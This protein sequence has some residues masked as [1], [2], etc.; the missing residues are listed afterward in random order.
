MRHDKLPDT[1]FSLLEQIIS[2]DVVVI[3]E[4]KKDVA[5]LEKF[6]VKR[7]VSLEGYAL[8]E[9]VERV[10]AH[11]KRCVVLTDLD[12]KGRELYGTLARDLRRHGVVVDD[13]LRTFLFKETAI[14]QIEGLGKYI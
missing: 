7:I 3:V 10:C 14:R 12:K 1:F 11:D 8:F 2:E 6:G 4:G 9:V 5:A 13:S